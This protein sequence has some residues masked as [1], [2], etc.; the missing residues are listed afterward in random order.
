MSKTIF[1]GVSYPM[2]TYDF[3]QFDLKSLSTWE[4]INPPIVL[5]DLEHAS[6]YFTQVCVPKAPNL[7]R[8]G[9]W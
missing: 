5:H 6:K 9:T 8:K 7:Y 1:P 4:P 3:T 2:S